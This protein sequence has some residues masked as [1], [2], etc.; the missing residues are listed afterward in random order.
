[1]VENNTFLRPAMAGILVEDDAE[2]WFESGP[3]RDLLIRSNRFIRCGISINP[4]TRSDQPGEPVH[5]NIRI[6]DNDFIE[7]GG[8]SARSVKGL[9]VVSNRSPS[10]S[11]AV[12][13]KACTGAVVENNSGRSTD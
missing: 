6:E 10:G 9:R 8:V 4:H 13:V 7:G 12:N 2:G 3:V 1:V 5:E 11:V